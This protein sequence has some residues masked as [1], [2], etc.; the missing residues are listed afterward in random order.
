M[1]TKIKK[2]TKDIKIT[3]ERMVRLDYGPPV[4]PTHIEGKT[5][6]EMLL[7]EEANVILDRGTGFT[8]G[9]A[10]KNAHNPFLVDESL[11]PAANPNDNL[12]DWDTPTSWR[13]PLLGNTNGDLNVVTDLDI[14]NVL[15]VVL[16]VNIVLGNI[17]PAQVLDNAIQAPANNI[18]FSWPDVLLNENTVMK[19]FDLN[20]DG[21][22][23]ILD[24]VMIVQIILND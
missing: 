3:I 11:L 10:E 13:Y 16:L 19:P 12:D 23:N 2:T 14:I 7:L 4:T 15:D 24:I 21:I 20:E 9:G 1:I 17:T 22:T 18:W 5:P 6:D 8:R